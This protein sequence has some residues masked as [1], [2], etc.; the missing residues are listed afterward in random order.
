MV[1]AE[2]NALADAARVGLPLKDSVIYV[3]TYPCHNCAKHLVAAGVKKIVFI[4]PYPKSKAES[5]FQDIVMPDSKSEDSVSIEHFSGIS[6]R[7]FRDIFEKSSRQDESGD[8]EKWYKNSMEP[9]LGNVAAGAIARELFAL[10][11]N[12]YAKTTG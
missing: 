7:R 4:E 8:L 12:L 11:E 9:R 10:M 6:P 1:H 5:L 2:M 3:T